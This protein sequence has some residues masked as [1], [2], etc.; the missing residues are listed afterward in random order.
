[1]WVGYTDDLVI[2]A[3][4]SAKLQIA[5]NILSNLLKKFDLV[6]CISKTETMILNY[7][8]DD[9]PESIVSIDGEVI[10]NV[11]EF[12]YLGTL[13]TNNELGVAG[14]E[15]NRRIGM[16]LNKFSE[17]KKLLCNYRIHLK[18]RLRYYEVYIGS[19]LCYSCGT[20][21]LTKC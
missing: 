10:D 13:I 1:M 8:G 9:Y 12:V 14:A 18:I 6:I 2:M 15:V 21:T 20:W 5:A 19:R 3:N 11:K 7:K 16:A 17:L 4:Y